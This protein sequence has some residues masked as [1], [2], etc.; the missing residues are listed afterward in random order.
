MYCVCCCFVNKLI[1]LWPPKKIQ[2]AYHRALTM[3]SPKIPSLEHWA[4][5]RNYIVNNRDFTLTFSSNLYLF[6]GHN[7]FQL[8]TTTALLSMIITVC[9]CNQFMTQTRQLLAIRANAKSTVAK[10]PLPAC[11]PPTSFALSGI[12]FLV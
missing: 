9:L 12:C 4:D 2:F 6:P 11:L 10:T 3:E 1:V 7:H 8:S 5:Y